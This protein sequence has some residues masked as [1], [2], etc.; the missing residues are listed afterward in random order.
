KTTVSNLYRCDRKTLTCSAEANVHG[1]L[2]SGID[3]RGAYY[4]DATQCAKR[5][6]PEPPAELAARLSS[7]VQGHILGFLPRETAAMVS[8]KAATLTRAAIATSKEQ[9]RKH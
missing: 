8:K 5:C 2:T 7:D 4:L 9:E 3:D 1:Y 6:V